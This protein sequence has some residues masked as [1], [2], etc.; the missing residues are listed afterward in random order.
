MSG[1]KQ[2]NVLILYSDQHTAK[3]L[4]CYGNQQIKTPCLDKLA[5]EG[6]RM[7]R[8]YT[9]NPICTPSRMC[10]LSGQYAHNT[11][12]YGLAGENPVSLPN[13]FGYFKEHGYMT[14]AAG[15]LHTPAGWVSDQCDFVGDGYGYEVPV[16]PWNRHLEEGCQGLCINEYTNYLAQIDLCNDRDDKILQEWYEENGHQKGQCVDSRYSRIPKEHTIEKWSANCANHFI[17]QAVESGKPFCFWLTVPRPHQTYAPAK[18]FWDLYKEDELELPANAEDKMELRSEAARETQ[19]KFQNKK[20]WIAFGE[21][22]FESA[23]K[24]VL[25]GYYACVSQMDDAMGT[26]LDKLDE[27]GIR[28][29]TIVIYTTDHGEFAGEHGM[30]EKAPGIGFEC[31]TRVPMIFSWK[32]KLPENTAR[33]NLIESVDIFPT[34]SKLAGIPLPDWADGK[35]ATDL[36]MSDKEI[37]EFA[38]TENPNTKTIHTKKYK[39]TQYLPEFQGEDFGELYDLEKDP[40]ELNN[41]YFLPEYQNVVQDLRYK[42][43]CWLIRT[44]RVKTANPTIPET[45]NEKDVSGGISWDLAGYIGTYD[46]DGKVGEKFFSELIE[47][48]MR[49]YL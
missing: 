24:R 48:G 14:G 20:D 25:H 29:N 19:K 31:V 38:V 33:E 42:L 12:Y 26:V 7:D 41:L 22:D 18:E 9:Q 8:A 11:G 34:I 17:E 36:L 49:N 32:G 35:D 30:I 47:K 15:K 46:R 16:K 1:K 13:L 4:G 44:T 2:P 10:M 37:H 27:L 21:K 28:E 6:I 43:Y 5:K 39:L 3:A 45:G 23:R 40:G